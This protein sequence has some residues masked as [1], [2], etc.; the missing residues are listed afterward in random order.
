MHYLTP[1]DDLFININAKNEKV[2]E[3]GNFFEFEKVEYP[4]S[5]GI[6]M[7]F[8]GCM[9]PRK[10]FPFPEGMWAVNGIKRTVRLFLSAL[11][12]YKLLRKKSRERILNALWWNCDMFYSKVALKDRF[13]CPV[14]KESKFFTDTFLRKMGL[15][16]G[17]AERLSQLPALI[18]EY[19][20][21]YR[22]RLQDI[23]TET[24][25]EGLTKRPISELNRLLGI[26]KKRDSYGVYLKTS[27]VVRLMQFLLF[28]PKTRSIFREVFEEIKLDH[29]QYDTCDQYWVLC[30]G[31]GYDY[32]GK[33]IKERLAIFTMLH[34]DKLP[35]Q[36]NFKPNADE[37][38]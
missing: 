15:E 19:D 6:L 32:L 25:K 22:Y 31:G 36:Y 18:L 14:A 24:T 3:G 10:G 23:M 33:P 37:T 5:G 21:A 38:A 4:E 29:L 34:G 12:P 16:S 7:Y 1:P 2:V 28:F 8:Q 35:Q 13:F 26:M 11:G 9:F 30:K 17:L 20:D 27:L